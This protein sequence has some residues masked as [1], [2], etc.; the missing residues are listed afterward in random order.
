MSIVVKAAAGIKTN[1][2]EENMVWS[3][4]A[5]FNECTLLYVV[6]TFQSR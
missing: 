4:S 6:H 5:L 3:Q 1:D 2:R